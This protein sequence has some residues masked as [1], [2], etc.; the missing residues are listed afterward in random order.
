MFLLFSLT[1]IDIYPWVAVK[2][3]KWGGLRFSEGT[4]KNLSIPE[5]CMWGGKRDLLLRRGDAKLNDLSE[6]RSYI[7]IGNDTRNKEKRNSMN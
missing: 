5:S 1:V 6:S 4:V 2:S 7:R 3:A